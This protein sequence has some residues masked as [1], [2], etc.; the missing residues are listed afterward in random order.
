MIKEKISNLFKGR[1]NRMQ[2]LFRSIGVFI[3]F[4]VFIFIIRFVVSDIGGNFSLAYF[5]GVLSIPIFLFILFSLVVKRFHDMG[6]PG[7]IA[8]LIFV[9]PVNIIVKFILILYPGQKKI[10]IYGD[11]PSKSLSLKKLLFS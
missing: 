10:N 2:Y 7:I 9:P 5:I 8:L 4:V 11:I 1:I 6:Y 3:S